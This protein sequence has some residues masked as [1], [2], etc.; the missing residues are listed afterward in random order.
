[1]YQ[2][3]SF[4]P[5]RPGLRYV[6]VVKLQIALT[7]ICSYVKDMYMCAEWIVH[8]SSRLEHVVMGNGALA[9]TTSRHLVRPFCC[10]IFIWTRRILLQLLIQCLVCLALNHFCAILYFICYLHTSHAGNRHCF[11]FWWCLSICPHIISKA[12]LEYVFILHCSGCVSFC[13]V[14]FVVDLVQ[15]ML[16]VLQFVYEWVGIWIV[17]WCNINISCIFLIRVNL[18]GH[19]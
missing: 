1:L 6:K 16:A 11:C 18:Y 7:F 5:S 8:S 13:K 10:R 19:R 14:C 15:D 4:M 2:D 17:L 3:S 12:W 9:F